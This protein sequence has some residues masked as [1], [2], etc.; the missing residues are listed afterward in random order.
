MKTTSSIPKLKFVEKQSWHYI[1]SIVKRIFAEHFLSPVKLSHCCQLVRL[2]DFYWSNASSSTVTKQKLLWKTFKLRLQFSSY[3]YFN[4]YYTKNICPF[5]ILSIT[6]KQT[7]FKANLSNCFE[8][9][10]N[11]TFF[12]F[13]VLDLQVLVLK[14]QVFVQTCVFVCLFDCLFVCNVVFN[15]RNSILQILLERS[16]SF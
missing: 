1:K 2:N 16:I 3:Q 13:G 15:S 8:S 11:L 9:D 12:S 7:V 14:F 6:R 5:F 10:L 4:L